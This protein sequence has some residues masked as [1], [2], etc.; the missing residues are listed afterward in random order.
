MQVIFRSTNK[1][2]DECPLPPYRVT[3]PKSFMSPPKAF[4]SKKRGL[5]TETRPDNPQGSVVKDKIVVEAYVP[6]DPG[7]Y[8]Q[9][10]PKQNTVRFTPVQV[11]CKTESIS[12]Q[13]ACL[14]ISMT[15]MLSAASG[16]MSFHH[17]NECMHT[18]MYVLVFNHV[19]LSDVRTYVWMYVCQCLQTCMD[20]WMVI[21]SG[22]NTTWKKYS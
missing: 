19:C 22:G 17:M 21:I 16:L 20:G 6:P 4:S 10:K 13:K 12:V 9:D 5:A 1:T 14:V 18:C 2:E 11:S 15:F 3:F 7:P 8:P